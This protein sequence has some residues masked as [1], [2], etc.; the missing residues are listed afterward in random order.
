[1][2]TVQGRGES[3]KR[4]PRVSQTIAEA[5]PAG[6]RSTL[7]ELERDVKPEIFS[8]TKH[9]EKAAKALRRSADE[10]AMESRATVVAAAEISARGDRIDRVQVENRA[11]LDKLLAS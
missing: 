5:R 1:M 11:S 4:T 2:A 6:K 7:F 10:L 9:F 8:V 3:R